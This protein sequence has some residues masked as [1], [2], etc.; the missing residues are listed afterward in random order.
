MPKIYLRN[1][2]IFLASQHA[3]IDLY[4]QKYIL[5]VSHEIRVG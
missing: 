5:R 3:A 4:I 1:P 2:N